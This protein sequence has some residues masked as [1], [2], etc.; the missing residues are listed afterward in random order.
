M[1]QSPSLNILLA[2][3]ER[4]VAFSIAVALKPDG[5]KVEIVTDGEEALA[6]LIVERRAFD[7]LITDNNMP[8][9]TGLELVRRLRDAAFSGKILVLSAHLSAENRAAYDALGVDGMIPKPFDLHQLRALIRQIAE[10]RAA[11]SPG[12]R[13]PIRLSPAQVERLLRSALSESD[14]PEEP[15]GLS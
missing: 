2:E 11:V 13:N 1:N 8:R 12:Q 9:M 4:S 14:E 6:T 3:D 5:H 7:L 10:E 15:I